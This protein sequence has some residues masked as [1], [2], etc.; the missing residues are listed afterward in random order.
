MTSESQIPLY[1][2]VAIDFVKFSIYDL[3]RP[4]LQVNDNQTV[5]Q[6]P[7]NRSDTHKNIK[8]NHKTDS[9][10]TY[11]VTV[12]SFCASIVYFMFLMTGKMIIYH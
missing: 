9:R 12:S 2:D 1:E 3:K 11:K 8:I 6:K 10:R 4:S 5:T 7:D